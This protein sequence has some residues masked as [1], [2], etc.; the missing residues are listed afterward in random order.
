MD[1]YEVCSAKRSSAAAKSI[2]PMSFG[3][4]VHESKLTFSLFENFIHAHEP[5]KL[6]I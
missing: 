6:Q 5:F 4:S 1:T 2:D 3:Q